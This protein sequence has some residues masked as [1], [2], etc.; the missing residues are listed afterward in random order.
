MT[1]KRFELLS[2]DFIEMRG[3]L[4]DRQEKKQYN[5]S[6]Y[7]LVEL[8]NDILQQEYDLKQFRDEIISKLDEIVKE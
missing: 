5:L 6:I 7:S 8:F 3:V 1:N 4:Y 2:W